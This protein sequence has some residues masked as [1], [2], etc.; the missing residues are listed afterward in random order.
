[1]YPDCEENT[2]TAFDNT[3]RI[4]I[5][6]DAAYQAIAARYP[7]AARI[8]GPTAYTQLPQTLRCTYED[9]FVLLIIPDNEQQGYRDFWMTVRD[10]DYCNVGVHMMRAYAP[11]N[12]KALTLAFAHSAEAVQKLREYRHDNQNHGPVDIGY[13]DP[14]PIALKVEL[15]D[16]FFCLI[17][18][19]SEISQDYWIGRKG[20]NR[21]VH[22]GCYTRADAPAAATLA[23]R[24]AVQGRIWLRKQRGWDRKK[25]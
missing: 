10:P 13:V 7:A 2:D 14:D 16:G 4:V 9:D 8:T 5:E 20:Y 6:Y 23:A 25:Q 24:L 19:Y 15:S 12:E 17:V 3:A 11:T 22:M 21:M 18:D 1:M